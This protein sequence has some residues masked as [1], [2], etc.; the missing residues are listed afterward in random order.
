MAAAANPRSVPRIPRPLRSPGAGRHSYL[1]HRGRVTS[2]RVE[3]SLYFLGVA[4]LGESE[5]EQDAGLLRIQRVRNDEVELVILGLAVAGDDAVA[6]PARPHDDHALLA[7]I[8]EGWLDRRPR[9]A[10]ITDA[11]VHDALVA[12][13]DECVDRDPVHVGVA[14]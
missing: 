9:E 4:G 14:V 6:D 8:D 7:R 12:G 5:H 10:A 1:N 11:G 13:G 2:I 3:H